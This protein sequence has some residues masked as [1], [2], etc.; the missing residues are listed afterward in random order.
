MFRISST[1]GKITDGSDTGGSSVIVAITG[2]STLRQTV[3]VQGQA[4]NGYLLAGG[5]VP[6]RG[7]PVE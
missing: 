3:T 6:V 2:L 4:R 7:E 5:T 1:G